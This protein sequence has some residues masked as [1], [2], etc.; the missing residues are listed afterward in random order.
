MFYELH[1][2]FLKCKRLRFEFRIKD[3]PH[4]R[5]VGSLKVSAYVLTFCISQSAAQI[6]VQITLAVLRQTDAL[7]AGRRAAE[8]EG[9][10]SRVSSISVP[11][12]SFVFLGWKRGGSSPSL[13][14]V[15]AV[16][17]ALS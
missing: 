8:S 13:T 4:F 15:L 11:A 2:E 6:R 9:T 7:Q 14:F 12:R 16:P 5:R 1:F 3:M 10:H 17:Q